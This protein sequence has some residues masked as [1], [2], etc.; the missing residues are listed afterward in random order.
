MAKIRDE[1]QSWDWR[2]GRTPKFNV[3]R[4][5]ALPQHLGAVENSTQQQEQTLKVTVT[6]TNGL[7]EDVIMKI[8]PN[9]MM[10]DA[11]VE[12]INVITSLRGR[13]FSEDAL[14]E[15]DASFG[16]HQTMKDDSKQFVAD[17]VRKVMASV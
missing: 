15:L 10:S 7:V 17:C 14:D 12:D 11:F 1:F 5:F 13:R 16:M 2:F 9:L 4:T 8:P 3:S 6:V